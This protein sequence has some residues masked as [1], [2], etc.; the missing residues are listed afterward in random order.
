MTR[1]PWLEPT[2]ARLKNYGL[3]IRD[4]EYMLG[5]QES[6]CAICLKRFARTRTPVI[7]HDHATGHVRGLLCSPCNYWL[8]TV[9]PNK[10]IS[11]A[12]YLQERG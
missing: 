7:D 2:A 3:S 12:K 9:P 11:A 4:W 10:I 1:K 8:G 5:Q 6:K